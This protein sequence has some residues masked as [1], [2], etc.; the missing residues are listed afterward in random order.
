MHYIHKDTGLPIR[1]I[2]SRPGDADNAGPQYIADSGEEISPTKLRA[3]SREEY[4]SRNNG[5][6]PASAPTTTK[7]P[8][9][10]TPA[11]SSGEE[12][13]EALRLQDPPPVTISSGSIKDLSDSV[14]AATQK[15]VEEGVKPLAAN[16]NSIGSSLKPGD[17][18]LPEKEQ[19]EAATSQD[20][21]TPERYPAN[22]ESE[23]NAKAQLKELK[24]LN[25]RLGEMGEAGVRTSGLEKEVNNRESGQH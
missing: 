6:A 8:S 15:A 16:L 23:R 12:E 18:V 4:E 10:P 20:E 14:A 21:G 5:T 3:A 22:A 13:P 9:A 25:A 19:E 2:G 17:V 24:E 11:L 1:A 7:A